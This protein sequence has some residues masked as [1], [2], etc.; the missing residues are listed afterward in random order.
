M[1]LANGGLVPPT[2]LSPARFS[3]PCSRFIVPQSPDPRPDIPLSLAAVHTCSQALRGLRVPH[4]RHRRPRLIRCLRAIRSRPFLR[5]AACLSR[6]ALAIIAHRKLW[7]ALG[8]LWLSVRGPPRRIAFRAILRRILS[9]IPNALERSNRVLR[10][11]PPPA[12]GLSLRLGGHP[13]NP[14]KTHHLHFRRNFARIALVPSPDYPAQEHHPAAAPALAR[15]VCRD[16]QRRELLFL[17]IPDR[18]LFGRSQSHPECPRARYILPIYPF[19][20]VIAGAVPGRSR[21]LPPWALA[22]AALFAFAQAHPCMPFPD[23]LAYANEAFGG[24]SNSY[25]RSSATTAIGLRV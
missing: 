18:L 22:V 8:V 2:S 16:R 1:I 10:S 24:P 12:R 25:R 23:Y 15:A 11:S 4:A 9:A 5:R 6:T 19:S 3:S 20:I 17:V 7:S 13:P 14:R 21:A